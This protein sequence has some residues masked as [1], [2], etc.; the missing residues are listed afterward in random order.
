MDTITKG[1]LL[2]LIETFISQ[3]SGIDRRNYGDRESFMGDYREILRDGRDAR[4]M[5]KAIEWSSMEA[6]DL[7]YGFIAFSGRL[8]VTTS[9][10]EY[11][12]GQ[13]F[14]TEYRA[15]ACAVMASALWNYYRTPEMT[16]DDLRKLFTKKF[17]RGIARRW[18]R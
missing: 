7:L 13:Y 18:F 5:L 8:T 11:C 6:D 4:T 17:G 9:G 15:A 2:S 3:R 14:P 12:T 10:L 16:G 1:N